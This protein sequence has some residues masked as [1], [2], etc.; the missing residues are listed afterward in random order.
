[1]NNYNYHDS[2]YEYSHEIS[3]IRPGEMNRFNQT[4][5]IEGL[6]MIGSSP[7]NNEGKKIEARKN[8]DSNYR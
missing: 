3:Q 5:Q 6:G 4:L 7:G 2:S 8:L 1:V